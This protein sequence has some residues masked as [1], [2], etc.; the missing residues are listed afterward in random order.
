MK[1]ELTW[2][3]PRLGWKKHHRGKVYYLGKG[4]CKAKYD[5]KGYRAALDEWRKIDGELRVQQKAEELFETDPAVIRQI[6]LYLMRKERLAE[7][8][9]NKAYS[10]A[11][12]IDGEEL[13]GSGVVTTNQA[14]VC[15]GCYIRNDRG[16]PV[17]AH[18]GIAS[19]QKRIIEA[20]ASTRP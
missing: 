14:Q 3:E 11:K 2:F 8:Y 6:E 10:E 17:S 16:N 12:K 9:P 19:A 15:R 18:D 4:K 7:E 1:F 13:R 5:M 20:E